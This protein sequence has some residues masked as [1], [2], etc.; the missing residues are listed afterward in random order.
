MNALN[1]M[2]VLVYAYSQ[3]I[4]VYVLPKKVNSLVNYYL[5][6]TQGPITDKKHAI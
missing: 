1:I 2:C 4:I 5:Y 3:C 6:N